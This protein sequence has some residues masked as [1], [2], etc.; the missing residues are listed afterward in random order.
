MGRTPR[1]A[2]A[3]RPRP[4]LGRA[5]WW[6]GRR[7]DDAR[8]PHAGAGR[9][10]SDRACPDRR[11][12]APRLR[13]HQA[14]RGQ[15]RRLVFTQPGHRLSDAHLSRG[16]GLPHRPAR[17]RQAAL[18]HYPRGAR[19][20][21]GEPRLRRRRAGTARRHGRTR[22]PDAPA[23][24]ERGRRPPRA[25]RFADGAR[26]DREPARNRGQAARRRRRCGGQGGRDPGGRRVATASHL[27][28]HGVH[29]TMSMLDSPA[30]AALLTQLFAQADRDAP[31]TFEHVNAALKQLP[32]P[33]DQRQRAELMRD[34]YM[35]ISPDVGRLLYM[36]ART[37]SA[38]QVVEFG[39]SFGISGIHL[40]AAV[41]DA[42]GGRL[43]ATELDPIKAERAAHNFRA[44]GLSEVI[45]LR[46][47]DAFETLKSGL[48]GGIDLL[49]LDGWK[50]AYLPMLR[51]LEPQLAPNALVVAD[52]LDIAPE[53]LAPYLDYVRK[54]GNGYVSVEMPLGDRIELSMRS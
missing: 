27:N 39:T 2:W 28:E 36:L 6:H 47:G 22:D 54:P 5:P 43:I 23:R 34:V 38:K 18:H 50:E 15:D 1:L 46:V 17:G 4:G 21:R 11:A 33:P 29:Q 7:R 35:P 9:F 44:A 52:D 37:R 45:D 19:A 24:P 49:L 31:A 20:S 16:G 51:F 26:G 48:G 3:C 10:A 14:A 25:E 12:A 40:A 41:R 8:R 42:G 13:D 30:V 53:A 32:R